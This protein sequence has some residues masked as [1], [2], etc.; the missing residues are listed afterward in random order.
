[1][2]MVYGFSTNTPG[3]LTTSG[4]ANTAVETLFL[5]PGATRPTYLQQLLVIGKAAAL[6]SISGIVFRVKRW[7]TASTAGTAF[8]PQP[9]DPGYQAALTTGATRPTAGSGGGTVQTVFGCGAAGPGGFVAPNMDSMPM[10]PAAN[11]GS[12]AVDDSSGSTSL[13]F[14]ISGDILE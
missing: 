10:L 6:T 9:K 12:I 8:T 5:K 1:M 4:V 14:E 3:N 13:N 2:P 7:T 11:A